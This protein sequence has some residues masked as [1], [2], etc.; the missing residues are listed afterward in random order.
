MNH[1]ELKAKFSL[2]YPR[3]FWMVEGNVRLSKAAAAG[4]S[5]VWGT[6]PLRHSRTSPPAVASGSPVAAWGHTVPRH[7][8]VFLLKM[9]TARAWM[10]ISSRLLEAGWHRVLQ[11]CLV[12]RSPRELTA[13]PKYIPLT[14]F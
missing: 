4:V 2:Y 11:H 12:L 6:V 9:F 13:Q 8:R 10:A 7:M 14:S 3:Q 1:I 5:R